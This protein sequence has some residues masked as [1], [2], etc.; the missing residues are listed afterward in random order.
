[1]KIWKI[2]KEILRNKR[3]QAGY[4][5]FLRCEYREYRYAKVFPDYRNHAS[6]NKK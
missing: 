6:L 2:F 5:D 3:N 1:M 4:E